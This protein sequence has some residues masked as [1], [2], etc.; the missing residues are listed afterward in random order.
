MMLT[1]S[2]IKNFLRNN[3]VHLVLK[4]SRNPFILLP[5]YENSDL[6]Q[7]AKDFYK[8]FI[9]DITDQINRTDYREM[10]LRKQINLR[11]YTNLLQKLDSFASEL[12]EEDLFT[13]DLL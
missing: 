1:S 2:C 5:L 9:D 7:E 6:Y 8:T 11:Y 13:W 10:K 12:S 3:A 4:Q